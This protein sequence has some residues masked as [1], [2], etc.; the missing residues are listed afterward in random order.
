MKC[1]DASVLMP[2]K[3]TQLLWL[4]LSTFT[5]MWSFFP[6]LYNNNKM[7]RS[8]LHHHSVYSTPLANYYFAQTTLCWQRNYWSFINGN[9]FTTTGCTKNWLCS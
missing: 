3:I 7:T 2:I 1:L 8:Q 9:C 5:Q 4:S 6:S